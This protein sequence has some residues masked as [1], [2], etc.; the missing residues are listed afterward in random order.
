MVSHYIK[1][2]KLELASEFLKQTDVNK[3]LKYLEEKRYSF[4]TIE[5]YLSCVIHYF[6]WRRTFDKA[7]GLLLDESKIHSFIHRH[8]PKCKCPSSFHRARTSASASLRLWKRLITDVNHPPVLSK[9]DKVL[10]EYDIYLA[11]VP[12]IVLASR[13]ARIRYGRELL[14][15]MHRALDKTLED[16][17][18]QD[19][20]TYVYQRSSKLAPGSIS[21]MVCA[22]GCFVTYLSLTKQCAIS[23]PLYIPRPK[24]V[25]AI[26][27][28][29]TLTEQELCKILEC[30]D[31]ET[32]M[33]KRDYCMA[34]CLIDLGLRTADTAG[35]VLDNID[36][37]NRTLTLKPGKNHRQ[38]ILPLPPLL[39][40]AIVDYVQHGRPTTTDR[41]LFVY[42]RA[43]LGQAVTTSAVR[44]AIIRG[45]KRT[46]IAV[47][48]QQL[49][50]FRHTM[51]TRLINANQAIKLIADVLG[52]QS[53][54]ATN[55]YTHV[56]ID[57]LKQVAMEWPKGGDA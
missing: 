45:F 9:Q 17:T 42:H 7:N 13:K 39:F 16:L 4:S 26:P 33:G 27:A 44:S 24:P 46:E 18:Q 31:L 25:H 6:S 21:A 41:A 10:H 14:D 2:K 48:K 54:E 3:Y 55:R 22:L 49:H 32:P 30:F 47:N 28:Y 23:L 35:I 15:W 36:W 12:G 5:S 11:S 8:L 20:A 57:N 53:Y 43:P 37:R 50:R 51:A 52:H 19:V 29:E 38:H 1:C 40:D 56:N 34:R